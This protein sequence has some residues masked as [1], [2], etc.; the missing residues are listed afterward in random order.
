MPSCA[1]SWR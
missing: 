1:A